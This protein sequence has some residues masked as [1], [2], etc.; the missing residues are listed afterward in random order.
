MFR[1]VV[2]GLLALRSG[3]YFTKGW[4]N[5]NWNHWEYVCSVLILIVQSR[6]T[7]AH[8]MDRLATRLSNHI[9]QE[10][11]FVMGNIHLRLIKF[12]KWSRKTLG[13][14]IQIFSTVAETGIVWVKSVDI[15]TIDNLAPWVAGSSAAV[16][17]TIAGVLFIALDQRLGNSWE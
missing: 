14:H 15:M 9:F 4:S 8:F 6:H 1:H 2:T 5:R 10:T 16:G 12:V 17:L 3:D 13:T 11:P 7:F